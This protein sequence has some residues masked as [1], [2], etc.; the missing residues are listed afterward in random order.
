MQEKLISDSLAVTYL[1]CDQL[2]NNRFVSGTNE[3]DY[4]EVCKVTKNAS[5]IYMHLSA[6]V[7]SSRQLH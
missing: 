3:H 2:R 5:G 6:F 1:Q 4:E 7:Y